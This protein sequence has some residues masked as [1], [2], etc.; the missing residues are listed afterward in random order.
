MMVKP[1]RASSTRRQRKAQV[2]SLLAEHRREQWRAWAAE[3]KNPLTTL[4]ALLFD[5]DELLRW[6]AIEAIGIVSAMEA[7]KNVDPVRRLITHN[8]WMMNDESGNVGWYAAETIGEILVNIPSLIDEF[9]PR[10]PAYFIEEPFERGAF[11]AVARVAEVRP[12]VFADQVDRLIEFTS[13]QDAWIRAHSLRALSRVAPDT[14]RQQAARFA[15]D[16]NVIEEYDFAHG[17]LVA[18]SLEN[19]ASGIEGA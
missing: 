8:F 5:A 4:S 9:A 7:E 10:L 3:A 19:I 18:R 6:R 15:G 1:D 16:Q 14:A 2:R 13:D 11:W 17:K 12:E